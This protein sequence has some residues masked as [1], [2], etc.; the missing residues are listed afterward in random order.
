VRFLRRRTWLT[1]S[2]VVIILLLAAVIVGVLDRSPT[3]RVSSRFV[4]GTPESGTPVSLDTSLYLPAHTP[5]PAVLLAHGFGGT[6]ADLASQARDLARHGYVVLTYTARGFGASGGLIHL[7]SLDYEV[8]DA[9]RLLDYLIG[10]GDVQSRAGK[11]VIGVAGSS[12]GG[13]LALLLGATDHRISA[14]A[15]DITWNDLAQALFPNKASSASTGVFKKLWAGYLFADGFSTPAAAENPGC[16]RFAPQ[17]CAL[18]QQASE[19]GV[20]SA[21]F[22]TLLKRSSPDS[23]LANMKAPTLLSQGEQDSLFDLAQSDA[24]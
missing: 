23:V 20:E 17:V 12:Y 7:D 19:T 11:P 5:A 24:N 18:Y 16:G 15:A 3:I 14:V 8:A 6:K 1:A 9:S 22:A 21:A 10:T 2:G 4:T 13:A